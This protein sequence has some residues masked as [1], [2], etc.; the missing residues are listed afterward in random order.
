MDEAVHA[1]IKRMIETRKTTTELSRMRE[2]DPDRKNDTEVP[3]PYNGS[4]RDFVNVFNILDR[5]CDNF[6]KN[7]IVK[8]YPE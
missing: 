7:L 2:H 1:H 6:L 5:T 8:H 4:D 3:D